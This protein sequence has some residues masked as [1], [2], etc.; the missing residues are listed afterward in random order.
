MYSIGDI[1]FVNQYDYSDG[2]EGNNH[3]FVIIDSQETDNIAISM[4]YFGMLISSQIHKSRETS[5]FKYNI[6]LKKD[7][8]NGLNCDSI[9][10]T[11]ELYTFNNNN[12]VMKIGTVDPEDVEE[13]INNFRDFLTEISETENLQNQC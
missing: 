7:A 9:V 3:L 10:K 13:F 2:T 8:Q 6:F 4:D 11:D 5:K 1:E 12:I